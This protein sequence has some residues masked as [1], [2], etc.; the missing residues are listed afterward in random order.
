MMIHVQVFVS[1]YA[2]FFLHK[3]L[4]AGRLD[5]MVGVCSTYKETAKLLTEVTVPFSFP[6]AVQKT[7]SSYTASPVLGV[8]GL[9]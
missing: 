4:G 8:L 9:F 1:T 6:L 3:Y 2:F 5:H 7:S